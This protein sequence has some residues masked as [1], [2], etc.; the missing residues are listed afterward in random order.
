M[1]DNKHLYKYDI[2]CKNCT[3]ILT[4][5][6][7]DIGESGRLVRC[8]ECDYE[9]VEYKPNLAKEEKNY[10][11][12]NRLACKDI[13][14]QIPNDHIINN[15]VFTKKKNDIANI[16]DQINK[17]KNQYPIFYPNKSANNGIITPK[18]NTLNTSDNRFKVRKGTH[19]LEY[20][21]LGRS[22]SITKSSS[23]WF[24]TIIINI[25][26]TTIIIFGIIIYNL[27]DKQPMINTIFEK[28]GVDLHKKNNNIAIYNINREVKVLPYKS[29]IIHITLINNKKNPEIIK[30]LNIYY[31][32]RGGICVA[33]HNILPNKVIRHD[34][35]RSF[36][37][38]IPTGTVDMI[39]V[40]VNGITL[41]KSILIDDVPLTV[42]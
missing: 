23:S 26:V 15:N 17:Q 4:V 18:S 21:N 6:I 27:F 30:S 42:K 24:F 11:D 2:S 40:K 7:S 35:K 20:H 22:K 36:I 37:F 8:S 38:F 14:K 41:I 5:N 1:E 19:Y 31:Y 3:A 9:W 25:L 16:T 34:D 39:S 13:D 33:S 10:S 28:I 32:N 29:D 12:H